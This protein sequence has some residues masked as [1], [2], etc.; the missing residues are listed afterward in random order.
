MPNGVKY[1]ADPMNAM[2]SYKK[3]KFNEKNRTPD[4]PNGYGLGVIYELMFQ[5]PLENAPLTLEHKPRYS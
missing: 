1:F 5:K 2:K 3:N 4:Q